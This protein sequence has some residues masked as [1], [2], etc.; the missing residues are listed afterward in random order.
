[1]GA[2][3]ER[4]TTNQT[5]V[6]EMTLNGDR[7]ENSYAVMHVMS[8]ADR[9]IADDV[10]TKVEDNHNVVVLAATDNIWW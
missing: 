5:R 4:T 6:A 10:Q 2:A 1:M 7:P 9:S 3:T 8:L